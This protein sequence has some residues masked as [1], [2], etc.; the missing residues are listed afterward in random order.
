MEHES[1]EYNESEIVSTIRF[2]S[3]A[4][5]MCRGKKTYFTYKDII[6]SILTFGIYVYIKDYFICKE[7]NGDGW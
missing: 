3:R 1:D 4:C 6:F 5:R 7:C 2:R